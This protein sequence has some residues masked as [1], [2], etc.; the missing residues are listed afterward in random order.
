MIASFRCFNFQHS[1]V[2]RRISA[3]KWPIVD[4]IKESQHERIAS[5][6]SNHYYPK[7]IH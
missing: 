4:F 2:C 3:S 6:C 1:D 5:D 7:H